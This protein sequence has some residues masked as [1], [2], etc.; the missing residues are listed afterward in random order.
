MTYWTQTIGALPAAGTFQTGTA[1]QGPLLNLSQ[2]NNYYGKQ[3][4]DAF[5]TERFAQ[6]A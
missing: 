4:F 5:N 6:G 2:S 1:P 3:Y